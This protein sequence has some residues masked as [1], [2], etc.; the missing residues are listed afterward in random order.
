MIW[1]SIIIRKLFSNKKKTQYNECVQP[2]PSHSVQTKYS[3]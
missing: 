1:N 2:E 3:S